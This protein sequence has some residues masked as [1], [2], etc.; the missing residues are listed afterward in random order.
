MHVGRVG[1]LAVALGVGVGVS[2]TNLNPDGD[3]FGSVVVFDVA[4][5]TAKIIRLPDAP[6]ALV[7]SADKSHGY[8]EI[9]NCNP[10]SGTYDASTVA[11]I[12]LT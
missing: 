8:A 6:N 7:L 11:I 2:I 10:T 5:Q 12:A 9:N 1:A 4:T 3:Y